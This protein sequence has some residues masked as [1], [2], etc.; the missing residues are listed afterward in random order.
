MPG[1][2][3][4]NNP[5][6]KYKELFPPSSHLPSS[7]GVEIFHV[8]DGA[9]QASERPY[10]YWL[11]SSLQKLEIVPETVGSSGVS[12]LSTLWILT[13]IASRLDAV[14]HADEVALFAEVDAKIDKHANLHKPQES[15]MSTEQYS[16]ALK[17][18]TSKYSDKRR[19]YEDLRSRLRVA[20]FSGEQLKILVY[21][22]AFFLNLISF[23]TAFEAL[24][25]HREEGR[26][27]KVLVNTLGDSLLD[28]G[29]QLGQFYEQFETAIGAIG[30]SPK[31]LQMFEG[32]ASSEVAGAFRDIIGELISIK[33]YGTEQRE[34]VKRMW[35]AA[36]TLHLTATFQTCFRSRRIS[37]E[38]EFAPMLYQAIDV[39]STEVFDSG[40][41]V[42]KGDKYIGGHN[43]L[44]EVQKTT[45]SSYHVRQ[46]NS[47]DGIEES[48][49]MAGEHLRL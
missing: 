40:Y 46:F 10:Y 39:G 35:R 8:V 27:T 38:E 18:W 48:R 28:G 11:L 19:R 29:K 4:Q 24:R 5:K 23:E 12:P 47:G 42:Y 13:R 9:I 37:W 14:R 7:S 20:G 44:V 22:L 33:N 41:R 26:Y 15:G 36:C 34:F 2:D 45:D 31:D 43:M 32:V 3:T 49:N 16:E 17:V 1:D 30:Y 6:L 21:E 25:K